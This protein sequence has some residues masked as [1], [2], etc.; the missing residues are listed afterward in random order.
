M[1]ENLL[2]G[3]LAH[4]ARDAHHDEP[5]P[6]FSQRCAGQGPAVGLGGLEPRPHPYRL[7]AGNRCAG[8]PFP[9]VAPTVEAKVWFNRHWYAFS[10]QRLGLLG[11]LLAV[12]RGYHSPRSRSTARKA[13][14]SSLTMPSTPSSRRS[15]IWLGSFTVQTWTGRPSSW[16]Q[17]SSRCSARGTN[18]RRTG[19]WA[20]AGP[21]HRRVTF[22]RR[23]GVAGGP[24]LAPW[25]YT[26]VAPAWPVPAA[27]GG[28]RTSRCR[29]GQGRRQPGS[30]AGDQPHGR[31]WGRH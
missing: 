19:I 26:A 23:P 13:T 11:H 5:S 1:C 6:V 17:E 2:A 24:R 29:P 16:A 14:M 9:Q 31:I 3:F 4:A 28:P 12:H 8:R 7:N 21:Q 18:P 20:Q 25:T 30:S 22:P 10:A 27:G 15:R